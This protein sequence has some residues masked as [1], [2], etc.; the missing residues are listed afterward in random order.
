MPCKQQSDQLQT[1]DF[2]FLISRTQNSLLLL[3]F[4][5]DF[6]GITSPLHKAAECTGVWQLLKQIRL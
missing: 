5:E 1:D 2:L 6:S 4:S 3:L